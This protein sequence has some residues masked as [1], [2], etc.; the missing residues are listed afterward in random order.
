MIT[1]C[2]ASLNLKT[3]VYPEP[4]LVTLLPSCLSDIFNMKRSLVSALPPLVP[5]R[6][7]D[8]ATGELVE[9]SELDHCLVQLTAFVRTESAKLWAANKDT[10]ELRL[11][12]ST[13]IS[14]SEIG[15]QA[16]LS[17]E[18]ESLP[19]EVKAKSRIGRLVLHE[20]VTRAKS[21]Y[22]S[23]VTTK[24]EP[25]F[26]NGVNL[27]A[28]DNRMVVVKT[29]GDMIELI[30]NCWDREFLLFFKMPDYIKNRNILKISSPFVK[31]WGASWGFIFNLFEI[32]DTPIIN[33]EYVIG[34]DLGRIEPY[35]VVVVHVKSGSRIAQYTASNRLRILISK[36][37]RL[38]EELDCLRKKS[39][40]YQSLGISHQAL[41]FECSL[42]RN[43][44][45]H[46]VNQIT[47]LIA[48]EIETIARKFSARFV[49]LENLSWV[50]SKHGRS[51]W[52]HS[53]DQQ[54]ITHK[55]ARTGFI[56]KKVD[57]KNT[58]Q[59]CHKCGEKVTHKSGKRLVHC[60]GC[61]ITLDRDLNAAH[62][63]AVRSLPKRSKGNNCTAPA[64]VIADTRSNKR[65]LTDTG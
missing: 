60:Q 13:A 39:L 46:I 34:I 17:I 49:A 35:T 7:I 20:T 28:A 38:N 24:Q 36:R 40:A 6:I 9:Q 50:S 33:N 56:A 58:S 14:P 62:N 26:S 19:R 63:I 32:P 31:Q 45:N 48:T 54:A 10:L 42:T 23:S 44:C 21:Y 22:E 51:R 3:E 15:R 37:D 52:T 8:M 65:P 1:L 43:K 53:K 29:T 61:S 25:T 11:K 57:P 30:F 47:W 16:G 27:G 64:E 55:I 5:E 2:S 12:A 59:D 4:Y 41:E 18:I